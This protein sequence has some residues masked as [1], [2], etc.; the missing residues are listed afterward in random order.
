MSSIYSDYTFHPW[1]FRAVPK[2]F[3]DS[4]EN[5]RTYVDWVKET[6]GVADDSALRKRHFVENCGGGLLIKYKN[7][8]QLLLAAAKGNLDGNTTAD[9]MRPRDHSPKHYWEHLANQVAF[10]DGLA[11][12]LGFSAEDRERWY[13]VS[14]HTLLRHDG[15]TL[16][17]RYN[18]SMPKLLT[19]VYPDYVWL[20]WKFTHPPKNLWEDDAVFEQIFL[21]TQRALNISEREGWQRVTRRQLDDL[22][23]DGIFQKRGGL[24]AI[25]AHR[26]PDV[27]TRTTAR[28]A[29]S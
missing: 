3:F 5:L 10:M 24:A 28:Q 6:V 26:F 25:L 18:G 2:G 20:P 11:Q 21:H 12:R 4:S 15:V 9:T 27:A 16:L 23:V 14:G 29:E 7:S 19:A 22:G 17:C 1:K 13:G 8:P